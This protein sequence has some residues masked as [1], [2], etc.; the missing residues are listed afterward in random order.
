MIHSHAMVVLCVWTS[1]RRPVPSLSDSMYLLCCSDP[2][3]GKDAGHLSTLTMT[4]SAANAFEE[5]FVFA[6][7]H[8]HDMLVFGIGALGHIVAEF[9]EGFHPLSLQPV[10]LGSEIAVNLGVTGH[11][12][13]VLTQNVFGEK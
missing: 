11:V 4:S 3:R 9:A 8:T 10:Q 6:G 13:T 1:W 5:L 7:I 2:R 12:A